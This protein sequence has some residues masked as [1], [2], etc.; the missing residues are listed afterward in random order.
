MFIAQYNHMDHGHTRRCQ[1]AEEA[2]DWITANEGGW[3]IE[4]DRNRPGNA[5]ATPSGDAFFRTMMERLYW[6]VQAEGGPLKGF[7]REQ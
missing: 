2:A 5:P 6:R 3:A 4:D 1:T 7:C